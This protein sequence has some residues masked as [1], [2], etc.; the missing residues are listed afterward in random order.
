ML[1]QMHF[2]QW[3]ASSGRKSKE[4]HFHIGR[5]R[6]GQQVFEHGCRITQKWRSRDLLLL[7]DERLWR[8]GK[9]RCGNKELFKDKE[10][11]GVDSAQLGMLLRRRIDKAT[12]FQA[13]ET[14]RP[15]YLEC[16]FQYI[17]KAFHAGRGWARETARLHQRQILHEA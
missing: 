6:G 11:A 2:D 5:G 16:S 15:I 7:A 12:A 4:V 14:L 10:P 9:P 3:Q 13:S 8:R 17:G 1:H